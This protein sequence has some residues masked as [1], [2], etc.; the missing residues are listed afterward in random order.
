MRGKKILLITIPVLL[1]LA[2]VVL[3]LKWRS[4]QQ[5]VTNLVGAPDG[6]FV[7]Q[8]EKPL[9]SLRA[10]WEVPRAVFGDRD[11]DLRLRD[12]SPGAQF[13]MVTPKRFELTA[14]GGWDLLIESDGQGRLADGT[15]LVFPISFGGGHF[16][17]SCR[18][19]DLGIGYFKTTPRG[20]KL[21]GNFLLKVTKCKN[22][23][24]GKNASLPLL[25]V[26][27]SFKGLPQSATVKD[28]GEKS[29]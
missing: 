6:S 19:A 18:H 8:V 23:K 20:D 24:S 5:N 7:M 16:I 11:P 25:T 27:G 29:Q 22:A 26:R 9:L 15:R 2:G 13:G 17:F 4:N 1:L 28:E 10:P 3:V 21:D 14:D 12:T